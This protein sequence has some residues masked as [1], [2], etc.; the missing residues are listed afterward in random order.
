MKA[1]SKQFPPASWKASN[2]AAACGSVSWLS[3]PITRRDTFFG[4]CG[5]VPYV[6]GASARRASGRPA[7]VVLGNVSSFSRSNTT[8]ADAR[9]ASSRAMLPSESAQLMAGPDA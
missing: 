2:I 3:T 7:T 6:I 9:Q 4:R 8:P 1:V 5:T